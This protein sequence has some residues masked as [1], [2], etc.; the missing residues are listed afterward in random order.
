[1]VRLLR[2]AQYPLLEQLRLEEALMRASAAN[3]LLINDG[4]PA[5]AIVLGIS[6]YGAPWDRCLQ[7][8]SGWGCRQR[9][10]L[11]G[12]RQAHLAGAP[13]AGPLTRSPHQCMQL[14]PHKQRSKPRELVHGA[15][16]AAAGVPL[17]RRFTG[18]G[19][20]VVD[21]DTIF[22]SLIMNQVG[23]CFFFSHFPSRWGFETAH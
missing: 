4:V 10:E 5:P 23:F 11:G 1:M 9:F 8:G 19:T 6:G 2:L 15:A 14:H 7:S 16:A 3:W 22:T 12:L 17:L 21:G 18:G 20:V 13:A